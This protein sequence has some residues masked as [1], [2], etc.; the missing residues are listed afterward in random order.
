M[1]C[2][3]REKERVL[4]SS[5]TKKANPTCMRQQII[6]SM[7]FLRGFLHSYALHFRYFNGFLRSSK[8]EIE[9]KSYSI[10]HKLV[11]QS[12]I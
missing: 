3:Q 10:N 7:T 11:E 8:I 12:V 9:E 2:G 6:N 5:L 1:L 4:A